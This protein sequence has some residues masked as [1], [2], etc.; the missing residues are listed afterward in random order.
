MLAVA[1]ATLA[2]AVY[3]Q[4]GGCGGCGGGSSGGSSSTGC[5]SGGCGGCGGGAKAERVDKPQN[6][7]TA[8]TPTATVDAPEWQLP[9]SDV[10]EKAAAEKMALLI[11]F[12]GE[13]EEK[14]GDAYLSGKDV[15]DLTAKAQFI[16]VAHNAER[17]ATPGV[18]SAV[19]AS[20]ILSDNPSRD[21][22]VKSYPTFIVADSYGN[23]LYRFTKKPSAKELGEQFSVVSRKM[24]D[25][26]KKLAKNLEL[27]KKAWEA[28]DY[29]KALRPVL[30]NFKDG[31][32]GYDAQNDSIRIYHEMLDSARGEVG[33]LSD[34][35]EESV[36]RLKA[37]KATFK[38]TELEKEIE[39][40]LAS[41]SKK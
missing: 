15:K 37:L 2:G 39:V 11:F 41:N 38:G 3:A 31:L 10:L 1:I 34:G 40:V 19:P 9:G 18:Q 12:P 28:K 14:A 20:K 26:A 24:D 17:E 22:G 7:K 32:V 4:C 36:K 8:G 29:S 5:P 6:K 16:R 27:A 13:A 25:N 30:A 33:G 21:Y 35:S 23:E